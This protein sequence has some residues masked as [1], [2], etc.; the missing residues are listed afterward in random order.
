MQMRFLSESALPGQS[1]L[2]VVLLCMRDCRE[3]LC[4]MSGTWFTTENL[5]IKIQNS[6]EL[7]D[8]TL[9]GHKDHQRLHDIW[10]NIAHEFLGEKWEKLSPKTQEAKVGLLR[11]RWKSVRD[12]YKKELEKQYQESKSG[13]GSSQR[14]RYKFCGILEFMRKHHESAETEDSLPPDPDPEEAEIDAGHN[15][16]SDLEVDDLTP[17]DGDTA[18]LDES[19]S[20][21][22]D[23]TQPSTLTTRP[24]TTHRSS[25]GVRASTQGRRIAR[26]M[27][28]AEYDHKLITSIE[29]AV[30][31]MEKREEEIKQLKEPCTQYLLSLVP[32]LQKVPPD[33]QWAARHAISETLGTFLQ[34][35]SQAEENSSNYVT[36]QHMPHATPQYHSYPQPSYQSHRMYDPPSYPPMHMATR[37]YGQ[38]PHYPMTGP[39]RFE[40]ANR[41]QRSDTPVYTDLSAQTQPQTT[42][43]SAT[44]AF[45]HDTGSMSD[46][47][48]QHE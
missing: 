7:Y 35:Q 23:Q 17:Q 24:R 39:M 42:S 16:S 31:H 21:T 13:C 25:R 28:R 29:K 20:T 47:L 40:Q 44:Q 18:T 1:V 32:L 9:P 46:Y 6:P 14:T 27:S 2:P 8:K 41:Y 37:P 36:Q 10:R 19:D 3:G 5:I 26:G 15:T 11:K 12:S 45:I 22:A 48:A 33:K 38:Q 43:E 4:K 30:D 34:T